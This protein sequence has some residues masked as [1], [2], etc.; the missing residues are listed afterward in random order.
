MKVAVFHT[1]RGGRFYNAG[2]VTFL[3]IYD[4]FDPDYFGVNVY[5]GFENWYEFCENY[6]TSDIPDDI[7]DWDTYLDYNN[8][9]ESDKQK[10]NDYCLQH[11]ID[12]SFEDLGEVIVFKDNGNKTST[13]LNELNSTSGSLDLDGGYDSYG[14]CAVKNLEQ[15]DIKLILDAQNSY[16]YLHLIGKYDFVKF[17]KNLDFDNEFIAECLFNDYTIEILIEMHQIEG[18][19]ED[20][21]GVEFDG[22]N[23]IAL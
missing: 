1:G 12:F 17:L 18:V 11:S 23:Y 4:N 15:D 13:T 9:T 8:I 21:E 3:G 2:H 14:W 22:K 10:F 16:E 6:I 7:L 19:S 20:D 5:F